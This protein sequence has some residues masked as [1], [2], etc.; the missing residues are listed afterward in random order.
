M[1]RLAST[2]ERFEIPLTVIE[3]GSG[4]FRGVLVETSQNT[5]TATVFT[6]P[7]RL[8]RVRLPSAIAAGMVVR[9]PIGE[10]FIIADN[11]A[12]ELPA[13]PLWQSYKLFKATGKL[14]WQRRGKRTDP[15]TN[16]EIEDDPED[17]GEIW[18]AMEPLTREAIERRLHVNLEQAQF[19]AGA[20][21]QRDDVLGGRPVVRS[22][23]ELGVRVGVL[24]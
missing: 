11:G 14:L 8:L 5:Q 3:G 22:D 20:P 18:V 17:L 10:V 6:D 24:T 2:A 23:E 16:L 13:E 4:I 1:V 12:S 15:V 7:R 21:I 19:V 9:S